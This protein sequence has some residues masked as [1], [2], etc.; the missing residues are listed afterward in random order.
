MFGLSGATVAAL[1]T[2]ALG[3]YSASKGSK[4]SG[5]S[6]ST[7][8]QQLDPR[9][10]DKLFGANGDP[11]LLNQ[12][13]GMLNTPQSQPLQS[14]GETAGNYL[15]NYGNY[16]LGAI[17]NSA[18]GL[19]GGASA[20]TTSPTAWAVGGH[21]AAPSQNGIDLSGSYQSLLGGGD[22]SALNKS[23][24]SAVDMTNA[25]FNKNQTDVT[26]NLMRNVMPS[27]RSNSVL[28][29]Q[30]GGSRQGIAEGN[31]LS[32]YTNQ[33][34]SANTQL[35]AA[36]SMNTTA[37]AAGAYQQGQ[38]RALSATQ[39]LGAQQYGVAGQ[40]MAN[41][42]TAQLT[43]INNLAQ[44]QLANQSSQLATNA[45][46]NAAALGGAGLLG[47]LGSTAYGTATN[48]QNYGINRA[49]QVNGLLAPYMSANSSSSTSQPIYQNTAGNIIG[50]ATA[51][52]GLYN[53]MNNAGLFSG[54]GGSGAYGA[55][56]QF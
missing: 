34:T 53:T 24:Q 14:Y 11:G 13:Q 44:T 18:T 22:T 27:I 49:T 45:Q 3:A 15:N 39:G 54:M 30:Y 26:N 7:T 19:M 42:M 10:A 16:D 51:G 4:Q 48:N 17:R 12:Y 50:G 31:A 23:M 43:N 32:D 28:S 46:N 36:N 21:I 5:S 1:G 52:L 29:G 35:G 40:N 41:D 37:Q 8:Q 2:A 38:D 9:I 20:P 33:L 6:T 56:G 25:S 47:G 55:G